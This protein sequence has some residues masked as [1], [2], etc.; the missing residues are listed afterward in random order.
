MATLNVTEFAEVEGARGQRVPLV[1]GSAAISNNVTFTTSTAS[2]AFD[3]TTGVVR[4]VADA[5]CYIMFGT[6][7][8]AASGDIYLP[9]NSVEYFAVPVGL[10]YKVAAV[11]A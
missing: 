8:T 5:A 7:P 10:D 1:S 9:A 6:D 2:D 3:A 4:V 11:T